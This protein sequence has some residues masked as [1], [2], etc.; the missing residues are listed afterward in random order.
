ME[1]QLILCGFLFII[2]SQSIFAICDSIQ[3]IQTENTLELYIPKTDEIYC[4]VEL[5]ESTVYQ[6]VLHSVFTH[7]PEMLLF[8]LIIF[9]SYYIFEKPVQKPA[10]SKK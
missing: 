8:F 6:T 4:E 7:I 10:S 5:L 3:V 9:F 2:L 1:K